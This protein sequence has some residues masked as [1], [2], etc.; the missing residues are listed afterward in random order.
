MLERIRKVLCEKNNRPAFFG[1][2][3]RYMPKGSDDYRLIEHSYDIAYRE[4]EEIYRDSGE[5]YFEHLQG[6]ALII[7]VHLRI[8][9]ASMISAALL[10]DI[11]EDKEDW[12][13]ERLALEFNQTVSDYVWWMSKPSIHKFKG[14]KEA[15][16]RAY[17][18]NLN[19]APRQPRIIKLAD[20]LHNS[21]TMWDY[22]VRKQKRKVAETQDFYLPI[23]ESEIVLI[24]EIETAMTE[25][26][27]SWSK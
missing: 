20:R 22:P 3:G 7:M 5:Q 4:F 2:V 8:R 15:R 9:D 26:R 19:R 16:N 24:H 23:A 21:M 25:L 1:V 18:Q 13:S 10:H 27:D 11:I 6:V 12:S 17:H 14:N